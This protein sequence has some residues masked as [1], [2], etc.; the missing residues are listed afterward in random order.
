MGSRDR[1]WEDRAKHNDPRRKARRQDAQT[2]SID[3]PEAG[4]QKDGG[5]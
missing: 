3:M 2:D 4:K 5:G 1:S